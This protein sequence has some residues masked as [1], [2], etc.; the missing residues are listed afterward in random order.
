MGGEQVARP[1]AD[2]GLLINICAVAGWASASGLRTAA[3][4][5]RRCSAEASAADRRSRARAVGL[6]FRQRLIAICTSEAASG[7]RI[8]AARRRSGRP[9][10]GRSSRPPPNTPKKRRQHADR[11]RQRR[12]DGHGEDVAVLH[13]AQLMRQHAAPPRGSG[14]A[15]GRWWRRRR[16]APDC[17]RWQRRWA[18]PRRSVDLGIGRPPRGASCSTMP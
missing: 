2:S 8:I 11:A 14:D 10:A 16:H 15:A 4:P 3:G 13:M 7:A 9:A 12:G 18:D 1:P 6:V 17:G 5:V